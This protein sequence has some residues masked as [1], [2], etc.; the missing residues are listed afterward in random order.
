MH[1]K[2]FL[3]LG[4]SSDIGLALL[5]Q[6][7]AEEYMIGAHCFKGEKR[8]INFIKKEKLKY[9]SEMTKWLKIIWDEKST[10]D[11]LKK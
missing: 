1:K 3:I 8:I 10:N 11:I 5:K 6:L 7:N 2:K 9:S 4:A